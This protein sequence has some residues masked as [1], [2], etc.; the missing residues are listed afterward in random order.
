MQ[1]SETKDF[2]K[3]LQAERGPIVFASLADAEA[4]ES[5]VLDHETRGMDY[6]VFALRGTLYAFGRRL[7]AQAGCVFGSL[8]PD[9]AAWLWAGFYQSVAVAPVRLSEG[10]V[11]ALRRSQATRAGGPLLPP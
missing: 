6:V 3:V 5:F 9:G 8:T 1:L 10:W 2:V 7:P 4:A 11:A